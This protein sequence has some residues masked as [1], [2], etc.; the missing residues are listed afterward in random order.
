M[1]RIAC[2]SDS[3]PGAYCDRHATNRSGRTST[4]PCAP[5]PA[6]SA[7]PVSAQPPSGTSRTFTSTP[8]ASAALPPPGPSPA[9]FQ[10]LFRSTQ[11][12]LAR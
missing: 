12:V 7:Q 2:S 11:Q 6:V 5:T 8:A 4:A 9:V 3:A 1:A 10:P